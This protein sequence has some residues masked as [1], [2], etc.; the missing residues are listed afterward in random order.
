MQPIF[1]SNVLAF[2]LAGEL[3]AIRK[4]LQK[5]SVWKVKGSN[6]AH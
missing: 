5:F 1:G 6:V 3:Y 2:K 4:I